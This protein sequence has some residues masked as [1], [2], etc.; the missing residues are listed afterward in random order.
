MS[1]INSESELSRGAKRA[2]SH[3]SPALDFIEENEA[4]CRVEIGTVIDNSDCTTTYQKLFAS[5]EDAVAAFKLLTACARKA[6]SEP[7]VITRRFDEVEGGVE[8]I[9]DFSFCCQIES[10]NFQLALR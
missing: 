10:I 2:V 9:A 4:C 7:C 1:G 6:E 5:R 3:L 8:L